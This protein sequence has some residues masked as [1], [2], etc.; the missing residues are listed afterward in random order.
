VV[1]IIK[2]C[3]TFCA[4]AYDEEKIDEKRQALNLK[5]SQSFINREVC[6]RKKIG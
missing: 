4:T 5:A 3:L 2:S 6:I 1:E